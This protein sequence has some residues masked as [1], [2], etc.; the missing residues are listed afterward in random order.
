MRAAD[1]AA[2]RAVLSPAIRD[3][4]SAPSSSAITASAVWSASAS[5][6]PSVRSR[7][8]TASRQPPN[9]RAEAV[10]DLGAGVH[11]LGGYRLDRAA[12]ALVGGQTGGHQV[13]PPATMSVTGNPLSRKSRSRRSMSAPTRSTTAAASCLLAVGEVVIQRAGLDVGGLQDLVHP[14]RGIALPAE[15]QGC[16]VDEGGSA[17]VRTRHG[18]DFTR[19]VIQ[20]YLN[21]R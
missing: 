7:S 4:I 17:S 9:A 19:K 16:G 14:G 6:Q 2:S 15:Q 18:L 1:F 20:E 13:D 10:P 8:A 11:R 5:G 3:R 12:V 21:S